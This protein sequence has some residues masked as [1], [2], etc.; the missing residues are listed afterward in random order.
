MI[1]GLCTHVYLQAHICMLVCAHLCIWRPE[2]DLRCLSS[3]FSILDLCFI[4]LLRQNLT[5]NFKLISFIIFIGSEPRRSPVLVP[6][7]AGDIGYTIVPNI[8]CGHQ[9]SDLN[10]YA[11]T[12]LLT[13]YNLLTEPSFQHIVFFINEDFL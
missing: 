2:V 1:T 5:V 12:L 3:L 8:L 11:C 7:S 6:F 4:Y 10:S 13:N 9:K